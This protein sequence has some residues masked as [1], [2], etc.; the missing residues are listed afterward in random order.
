MVSKRNHFGFYYGAKCMK[1]IIIS[2]LASLILFAGSGNVASAKVRIDAVK[3][4]TFTELSDED[5]KDTIT[6]LVTEISSDLQ[7][8][9]VPRLYF[10][11]AKEWPIAASYYPGID[12]IYVNLSTF[13][14][15]T[16]A[17]L[18]NETVEYHLLRIMAHEVRHDFQYEHRLDDSDYGRAC[19][20]GLT[21]YQ[22][23]FKTDEESYHEQFIELDA[24]QYGIEY[25]DKY[26]K[27]K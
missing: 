12:Y 8:A 6:A 16:D 5:M 26:F 4:G 11:S 21:N 7:I 14:D 1:K 3:N 15:S 25:A 27:K 24:T 10:Y 23:Y 13:E 17:D 22:S 2:L 9:T 18:S 19:L 20:D